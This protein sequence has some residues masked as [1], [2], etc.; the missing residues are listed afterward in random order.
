MTVYYIVFQPSRSS[1]T[2]RQYY[3]FKSYTSS[4]ISSDA[5]CSLYSRDFRHPW[6][7]HG[8]FSY[9][10]GCECSC[11]GIQRQYCGWCPQVRNIEPQNRFDVYECALDGRCCRY[12]PRASCAKE[13]QSKCGT[14]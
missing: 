14:I 1:N 9:T 13:D 6:R 2:R 3:L 10:T 7:R 8:A 11:L 4:Q 12:G 5:F